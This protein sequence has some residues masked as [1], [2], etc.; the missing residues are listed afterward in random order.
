MRK[1]LNLGWSRFQIF[2]QVAQ[3]GNLTRAAD[4]FD[5]NQPSLTRHIQSLEKEIGIKLF[6]RNRRGMDLTAE[7]L[8]IFQMLHR[9]DSDF[10]EIKKYA[11]RS[12]DKEE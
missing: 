2:Y 5:T 3:I 12:K 6:I 8:K 9:I 11:V 7:G 10:S 1:R 4:F